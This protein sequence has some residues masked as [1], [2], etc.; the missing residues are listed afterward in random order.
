MPYG[1]VMAKLDF[2]NAFNSL[3]RDVMLQAVADIVPEIYQLCHLYYQQSSVLPV[4]RFKFLSI[5]GP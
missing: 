3:H 4:N 2:A 5:E 1:Y